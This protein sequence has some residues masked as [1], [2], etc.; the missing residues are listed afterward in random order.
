MNNSPKKVSQVYLDANATTQVLPQAAAAALSTM[1]TLFGNPSSSH[2]TGLQAKQIMDKTRQQAQKVTGA[3]KGK[4]IFTSGATEGIQTAILS[5]LV[6]AKQTLDKNKTYSILYGATEHKAVPE[7]LRHWNRVL[8]IN[9]QVKAIP[10]NKLGQLDLDF[11]AKEVPNAIMICTMAVNN[12]TGVY[13]DLQVLDNIIRANNPNAAWMV[14]CV[15]ALGKTPLNLANT[16]IDYAPFSGHKLYAPKGIGFMYVRENAAFTPV[17]AGGGQESGLRSGTE[18]IPGLAALSVIFDILLGKSDTQFADQHTLVVFRQKLISALTTA[19]PDVV[20]NHSTENSVATTLNFA[21]PGFSSKE[22]MD[23]FDAAN[24]RVSSGSACSS[25]VTRSFV[26]DAMG[27]PAW[28]SESAIRMSFGPATTETEIDEACTRII[29]AAQALRHSCL[30]LDSN[31]TNLQAL[32]NNQTLDGLIQFK[33]AGSCSWLYVDQ[34]SQSAIF[35]DPLPEVADRIKTLLTCQGLKLLAV[36]DTHGHAD[37]LSCRPDIAAACMIDEI[38]DTLGWPTDAQTT[39]VMGKSY[40]YMTIGNKWL[41]KIATPGHTG[42]SMSLLLT[43]PITD[44]NKP[45]H[46]HYA[47]CG[48]LILMD[49]LGRTNFATSSATAMYNSLQTLYK[50]IGEHTLICPSHDYNN[51]FTSSIAAEMS[52]NPL[53]AEVVSNA[54]SEQAFC[55]QKQ[56]MDQAINDRSGSEIMCGALIDDCQK[57]QVLEYDSEDLSEV[58]KQSTKIKLIDIREP[59]EYSLQHD[60]NFSNNVPLTRLVQ[61]VQENQ[62]DKTQQLVLVCRSGSRSHIAAQALARLGFDRVGH[63]KGGYALHQY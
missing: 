13:Q 33:V 49:S 53:L 54:I 62:Q 61:F 27:L 9:A 38:T 59:H 15:Q 11:I 12:E 52:R 46:V 42:D 3:G 17:I 16:S 30:T 2:V 51:E 29:S 1:E 47:F 14:D 35:I 41:I 4:I 24:I 20:F 44:G 26:L 18:N 57:H 43:D 39:V 37:H 50:L 6:K 28:Q 25:K 60:H 23:L 5:A 63:L 48:D 32:D 21:V 7:S 31:H 56:I 19:F 22:I 8:D 55:Q 34:Q 10:V 36:I 58:L 40:P 45:L